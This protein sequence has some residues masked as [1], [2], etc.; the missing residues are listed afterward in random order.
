MFAAC[1]IS[2]GVAQMRSELQ[3]SARAFMIIER[4]TLPKQSRPDP[5]ANFKASRAKERHDSKL[6]GEA[7]NG[8]RLANTVLSEHNYHSSESPELGLPIRAHLGIQGTKIENEKGSI[9]VVQ[10]WSK[11]S[12]NKI[13]D[14]WLIWGW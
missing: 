14:P 13:A 10:T 9:V 5:G 1:A 8:S 3:G 4:L 11:G 12:V 6:S 7:G 2:P